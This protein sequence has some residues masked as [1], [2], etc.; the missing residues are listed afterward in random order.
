MQMFFLFRKSYKQILEF[1][2]TSYSAYIIFDLI[3]CFFSAV[4]CLFLMLVFVYPTFAKFFRIHQ[5]LKKNTIMSL[6][7]E[8]N[9]KYGYTFQ[10]VFPFFLNQL[11]K[12]HK[13]TLIEA[14]RVTCPM[15]SIPGVIS[16]T[17]LG[18]G[19]AM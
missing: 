9:Q 14:S 19:K 13:R 1:F 5:S 7:S 4:L 3:I 6:R 10:R 8:Q 15:N 2:R 16:G 12:F 11:I 18:Q 17:M